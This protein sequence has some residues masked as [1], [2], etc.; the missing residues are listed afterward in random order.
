MDDL[1]TYADDSVHV[2][3]TNEFVSTHDVAHQSRHDIGSNH[4]LELSAQS[5]PRSSWF[6]HR[7]SVR[8]LELT[9]WFLGTVFSR[10]SV[11]QPE[12]RRLDRSRMKDR[13]CQ[14]DR[15]GSSA[16]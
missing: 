11:D 10:N 16:R 2:A 5:A 8:I 3:A 13:A 14:P 7:P 4:I 9:F 15:D 6:T 1:S 12:A